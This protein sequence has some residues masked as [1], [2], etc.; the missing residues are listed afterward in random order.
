MRLIGVAF[1]TAILVSASAANAAEK[2]FTSFQA[3]M[4]TKCSEPVFALAD[5]DDVVVQTKCGLT[6]LARFG[7]ILAQVDTYGEVE[8]TPERIVKIDAFSE[9]LDF[10]PDQYNGSTGAVIF[11]CDNGKEVTC[12][13]IVH[14]ETY[15]PA[16]SASCAL[17]LEKK[18]QEVTVHLIAGGCGSAL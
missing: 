12:G 5:A 17:K 18:G 8:M 1:M 10:L 11:V 2:L 4:G 9:W 15:L 7:E 13:K 3:P 6:A 14:G 16:N